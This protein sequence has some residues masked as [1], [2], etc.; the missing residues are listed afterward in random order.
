[1]ATM[2]ST[3]R[4][5][6]TLNLVAIVAIAMLG[7]LASGCCT[8]KGWFGMNSYTVGV[9]TSADA[10]YNG[11]TQIFLVWPSGDK[12]D[13]VAELKSISEARDWTQRWEPQGMCQ[14]EYLGSFDQNV[15]QMIPDATVGDKRSLTKQCPCDTLFVFTDM[16]D[17]S[18]TESGAQL[19][20]RVS[21]ADPARP[22]SGLIAITVTERDIEI[23]FM[24]SYDELVVFL[25]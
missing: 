13:E 18:A 21:L 14:G 17:P 6:R 2:E 9:K 25:W 11:P 20:K 3:T 22:S 5:S 19:I 24:Q 12:F 23:Q 8:F 15:K 16:D 4:I 10:N 1:M 7:Q